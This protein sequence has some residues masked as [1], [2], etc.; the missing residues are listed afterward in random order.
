MTLGQY[1]SLAQIVAAIG[2]VASLIYVAIQLRQNTATMHMSAS[3]ARVQHD[4]VLN[5]KVSDSREFAA[6]WLK[7]RDAFECLDEV[8][9]IRLIFFNRSAIVQWHYMFRLR[10]QKLLPDE[11]WNEMIWC[12]RHLAAQRQDAHAAWKILRDSFGEPFGKFMD[13]HLAAVGRAPPVG[14]CPIRMQTGAPFRKSPHRANGGI[15]E[16]QS[17]Q[18]PQPNVPDCAPVEDVFSNDRK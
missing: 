6:I 18:I 10:A 7:G 1:A 3:T 5:S 17:F 2:V 13:T 14:R 4:A 16:R 9:R 15:G 12:I 11:D 8:E